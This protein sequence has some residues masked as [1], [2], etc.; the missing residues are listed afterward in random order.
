MKDLKEALSTG[1]KAD[2]THVRTGIMRYIARACEYGDAKYERANYL[3]Y[4]PTFKEDFQRLRQYLRASANHILETL[5][6]MEEHQSQDPELEDR[7]GMEM[8]A[9]AKDTDAKEDCPI[10]ASGLPHLAHAAASLMMA[11]EQAIDCGLLPRD[12]GQPWAELPYEGE[13]VPPEPAAKELAEQGEKLEDYRVKVCPHCGLEET[14]PLFV[15]TCEQAWAREAIKGN[16]R[17]A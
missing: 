12:P 5:D 6:S 9:Y 3:R 2:I 16:P 1:R 11:I 7:A 14:H 15:A 8:A 13:E 4:L 17:Y 10:G